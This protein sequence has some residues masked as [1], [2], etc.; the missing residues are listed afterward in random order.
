MTFTSSL[1]ATLRDVAPICLLIAGFQL[2][3]LRRRVA[4]LPRVLWGFAF[5]IVGLALFLLGLEMALFPLGE[6][7]AVQLT[8]A[9][10]Q[11]WTDY[12]LTYLFAFSMGAATAIAEPALI[13]VAHKAETVS[14]GA[15][16][17]QGLRWAVALGVGCGVAVG[18]LRIV[19]GIPLAYFIS[20]AYLIVILQTFFTPKQIVPLAYDSGG[21]ATSTV[22]VPLIT[23]LGLGLANRVPGRDPLIDG[24]GL[25]AFAALFPIMTV[26]A[27]AQLASWWTTRKSERNPCNSN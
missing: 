10:A 1:L 20:A 3:V 7:M 6:A 19:L 13:A 11:S 8:A 24:F 23:A 22:T 14:G 26:M 17:A 5:V 4:R 15:I 27:Y 2:F 9:P 18:A 21:V 12:S 16:Q 25:V